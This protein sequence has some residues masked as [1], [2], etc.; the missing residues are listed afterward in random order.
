MKFFSK[1]LPL[2]IAVFL[3]SAVPAYGHLLGDHSSN[4]AHSAFGVEHVALLVLGGAAVY[5]I[6]KKLS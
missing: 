1:K 2:L 4:L 5:G 6:I 3:V